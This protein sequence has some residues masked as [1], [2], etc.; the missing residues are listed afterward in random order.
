MTSLISGYLARTFVALAAVTILLAAPPHA[1]ADSDKPQYYEL[2]IYT[3]QSAEQQQQVN[4][5]WQN[6][7][8]PAYNRLGIQPIGVF[9]EQQDSATNKIYVLI[10]CDSL[11]IFAAIPANLAADTN[12]QAKPPTIFYPRLP[13]SQPTND[14]KAP[15]SSRSTG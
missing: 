14:S 10:P 11:D 15:C 8:V 1:A 2:R 4:D 3:T 9:T 5:Y 6:A 12:Y 13:Q 7:A